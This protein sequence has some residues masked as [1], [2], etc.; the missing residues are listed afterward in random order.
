MYNITL[1]RVR[2]TTVAVKCLIFRV[3][4]CS[5]VYP[6]HKAH[7]PYYILIYDLSGFTTFYHI[8][9][10]ARFSKKKLLNIKW[11]F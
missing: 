3:C 10:T 7:M 9:S 8:S 1:R 11:V 5:L 4:A 2:V 6:A